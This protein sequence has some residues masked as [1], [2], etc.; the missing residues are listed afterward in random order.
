MADFSLSGQVV[1]V[2]GA[3]GGIGQTM[4]RQFSDAG[5]TIVLA[6]R[7][8]GALNLLANELGGAPNLVVPTD[9]TDPMAVDNLVESTVNAYGRLDA[10]VNNAGG[11][12]KPC[13]PEEIVYSDWVKLIDVNLT[14]TFNCCMSAGRQMIKQ[15]SGKIINISSTAG[16]KGNPGM[17]HYSAAKAGI[18]SM[19]N[20]LA[21][22]WAK[23]NICVNSVVP[24][25]VATPAMIN[26]G[27]IPPAVNE[28]GEE[29]PRLTRP[30]G[31]GD[32]ASMCQFLLS[33]A[34]DL[35]TGEA[36]PVR[37]WE[38]SDRFWD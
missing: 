21:F 26:Y 13:L 12:A 37:S 10:I 18:L 34:A 6:S 20:N 17:L 2:T 22:S 3:A 23:H 4:T 29:I 11:G 8:E 33:P 16:T 31:P 7:N 27:I 35:V 15:K 36:I 32:V 9:I 28:A 14:A 19:T 25:M 30:P 38:K 5:A 24:G 1:I